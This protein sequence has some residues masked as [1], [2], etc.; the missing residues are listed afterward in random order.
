MS[1]RPWWDR[2]GWGRA[3]SPDPGLSLDAL[4]QVGLLHPQADQV[5]AQARASGA[6]RAASALPNI[7]ISVDNVTALS[8]TVSLKRLNAI[9][10]RDGRIYAPRYPKPQ[11][12]GWFVIVAE[13]VLMGAM[14][15]S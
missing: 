13:K 10:E 14:R 1:G 8:L 6:A 9:V 4:R 2:D 15:S 5:I 3:A 7:A 12:E 11:T